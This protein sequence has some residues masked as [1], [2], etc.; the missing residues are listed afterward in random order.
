MTPSPPTSWPLWNS[1]L[2]SSVFPQPGSSLST[3]LNLNVSSESLP[4]QAEGGQALSAPPPISSL[5]HGYAT[6]HFSCSS[7]VFPTRRQAHSPLQPQEPTQDSGWP[8]GVLMKHSHDGLPP[9]SSSL[10]WKGDRG[11]SQGP[12]QHSGE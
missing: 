9:G 12:A 1:E 2:L 10:G 3:G 6:D 11:Q 5:H 4:T 8:P 7:V